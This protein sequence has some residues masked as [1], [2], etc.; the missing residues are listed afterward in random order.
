MGPLELSTHASLEAQVAAIADGVAYDNHDIDDG[1][2]AGLLTLDQVL[3]V[4]FVARG[5][6]RVRARYPQVEETR[7]VR[8]LVRSQIGTMVNDVIEETRRRIG[9][10][11]VE[12]VEDVR[13]AGMTL[14]CFSA[15]MRD[16]ERDLKRFMYAN[17]YHH[18]RSEE[19]TSELQSLM[20]ISYAVFC[21]KK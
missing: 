9:A 11:K 13:A 16:E 12:T 1:L 15:A 5:W 2:R 14:A 21:L 6:E 20:R 17:L 7:L 3:A 4:P 8:E 10:A 18:P 19:H